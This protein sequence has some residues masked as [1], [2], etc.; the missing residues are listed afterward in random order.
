MRDQLS[1]GNEKSFTHLLRH[2]HSFIRSFVHC[3]IHSFHYALTFIHSF[4]PYLSLPLLFFVSS[5]ETSTQQASKGTTSDDVST[6]FQHNISTLQHQKSNRI[7][8][9]VIFPRT[10]SRR[11][12]RP[13]LPRLLPNN[14]STQS[15]PLCLESENAGAVHYNPYWKANSLSSRTMLTGTMLNSTSALSSAQKI[16]CHTTMFKVAVNR[17][18]LQLPWP[19]GRARSTS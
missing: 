15:G 6:T 11:F 14:S 1:C 8:A 4:I 2:S 12:A 7:T 9:R 5:D 18:W 13:R 17:P 19:R 16:E 10:T 3:F